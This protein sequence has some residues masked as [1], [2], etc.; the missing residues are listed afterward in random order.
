MHESA[1]LPAFLNQQW[2][3]KTSTQASTEC[4]LQQTHLVEDHVLGNI[5]A[6]P[7]AIVDVNAWILK[8]SD[9][10]HFSSH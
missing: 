4:I 10:S 6:T 3:T 5:M 8:R 2:S 7:K 1:L 9:I